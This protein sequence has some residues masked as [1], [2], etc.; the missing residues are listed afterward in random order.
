MKA[1][2]EHLSAIFAY[3]RSFIFGAYPHFNPCPASRSEVRP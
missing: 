2:A 3:E 1:A